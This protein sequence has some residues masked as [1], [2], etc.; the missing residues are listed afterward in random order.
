MPNWSLVGGLVVLLTSVVHCVHVRNKVDSQSRQTAASNLIVDKSGYAYNP[1]DKSCDGYP[2]VMVE[3]LSGTCLGMVLPRDRALDSIA[4]KGFVKPRTIIQIPRTNDFLVV[5]MGGWSPNNGRLFLLKPSQKGPYEIKLLKFPLDSPHGLALGPDGYFYVGEKT[6]ISK[7]KYYN[8]QITDWQ[9]VIGNIPRKEGFMHPLSQFTFDP[10]NGDLYINSGSPSDHCIVHG[11]GNYKTCPEVEAQGNGAIYRIPGQKL[12]SL[13]AGGIKFFEVVAQGL[14]NSMAMVIHPSGNLI[15]GENSRDFPELEEPYEE[16]NV[17]DLERG[18]GFHYG[19]PYCY[20]FHATSPEWKFSENKD[21]PIHKQ[22]IKPVNCEQ[23]DPKMPGEYQAPWILMP[24]HV[25]PLHMSYYNGRMFQDLFGG[26]LLVTWHGYQP[27]GQ[28]IVSYPVDSHGRPAEKTGEEG[29]AFLMNQKGSCPS[30]K[31]FSP[32]GGMRR[33][34]SYQEIISR[35]DEIKNVRP[36]GAPVSLTVAEDGSLWIVEDRENRTILRLAKTSTANYREN[37]AAD[38]QTTADPRISLLAWRNAIKS[39]RDLDQKYQ[40]VQ[41]EVITKNCVGCHGNLQTEEIA[42]DRYSNLDFLVKNEWFVPKNI[43]RSKLYGAI[44]RVEGYTPM[45]PADKPQFF[46]TAEGERLN[47]I[48]ADWIR[49]LP[50]NVDDSYKLVTIKDKRNIRQN[51]SKSAFA[52]G[53]LEA[54]DSVY[55]D[56]RATEVISAESTQWYKVYLVTEHS[57]LFKDKCPAPEDGVYYIAK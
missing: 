16:I 24:P 1:E 48:V 6:Q 11:A 26:Q 3:T 35:W 8:N 28:R 23:S 29:S 19:W 17:I 53:Q 21:N 37:C 55:I 57:R 18:K 50:E 14:R 43:E 15:Q 7:F 39:N 42:K 2:R 33:Q 5:D 13:P 41:K 40:S 25:A 54:G 32:H 4:Q 27:T 31:K 47:K 34:S 22:F 46:G 12:M 30:K 49:S 45:P 56:S 9:L 51:P 20:D 38:S 44:A 52:C 36:K 10:R